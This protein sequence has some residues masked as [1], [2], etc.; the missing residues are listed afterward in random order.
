[1]FPSFI[2]V[3]AIYWPWMEGDPL[4]EKCNGYAPSQRPGAWPAHS[5][6]GAV[7]TADMLAPCWYQGCGYLPGIRKGAP[8]KPKESYSV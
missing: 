5:P 6:D 3:D 1:M 2:F 7:F 4:H 8:L